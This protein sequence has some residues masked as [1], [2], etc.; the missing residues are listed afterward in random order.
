MHAIDNGVSRYLF[1]SLFSIS[2]WALFVIL[3]ICRYHVYVLVQD[4][5]KLFEAV[6]PLRHLQVRRQGSEPAAGGGAG[7]G[8]GDDC[9]HQRGSQ[10]AEGKE[11]H[12]TKNITYQTFRS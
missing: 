10:K 11:Q 7:R 12:R 1:I 4:K 2:T 5:K 6:C 9:T 3:K 8:C